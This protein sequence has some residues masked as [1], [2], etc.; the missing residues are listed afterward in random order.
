MMAS[1]S[2][3]T[4]GRKE[5]SVHGSRSFRATTTELTSRELETQESVQVETNLRRCPNF[6]IRNRNDK[7]QSIH[8]SLTWGVRT[9]AARLP[10][11]A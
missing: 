9:L 2:T 4:L 1:C 6:L 5:L 7:Q 8:D 10:R 3:V 11:D